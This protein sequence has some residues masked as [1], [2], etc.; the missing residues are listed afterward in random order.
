MANRFYVKG[1]FDEVGNESK[2]ISIGRDPCKQ[3]NSIVIPAGTEE[4]D[5]RRMIDELVAFLQL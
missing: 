2:T 1:D 5:R 4:I 3:T